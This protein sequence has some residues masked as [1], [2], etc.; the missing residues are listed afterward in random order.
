MELANKIIAV[1][2]DNTLCFS[3][4]PNLGKPNLPLIQYLK[5][6]K[7]SGSKIIL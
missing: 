3:D 4:W 1:D 7:A 2:F 5:K 6:Q